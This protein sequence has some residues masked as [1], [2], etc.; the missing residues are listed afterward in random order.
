MFPCSAQINLI[1]ASVDASWLYL[2]RG[3]ESRR[4]IAEASRRA[5]L[6]RTVVFVPVTVATGHRCNHGNVGEEGEDDEELHS[7]KTVSSWKPE[8]ERRNYTYQEVSAVCAVWLTAAEAG[9]VIRL[10]AQLLVCWYLF[11]GHG[12][13]VRGFLLPLDTNVGDDVQK[14]CDTDRRAH[15][16]ITKLETVRAPSLA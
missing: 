1:S 7:A 9:S 15:E 6:P 11:L 2:G 14:N 10:G 16:C 12:F 4:Y 5:V 13:W 3:S 8:S